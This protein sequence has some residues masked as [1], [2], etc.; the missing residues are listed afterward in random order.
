MPNSTFCRVRDSNPII[1]TC[2]HLGFTYNLILILKYLITT[3]DEDL[4]HGMESY[5]VPMIR[6]EEVLHID[7]TFKYAESS[8]IDIGIH[9]RKLTSKLD[10]IEIIEKIHYGRYNLGIKLCREYANKLNKELLKDET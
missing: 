2:Y 9:L 4:V 1:E 10:V 5:V 6:Q 3:K 7:R 8:V